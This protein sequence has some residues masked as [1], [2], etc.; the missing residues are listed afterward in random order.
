MS[1]VS[2]PSR[3]RNS[4]PRFVLV[5]ART[6]AD[7]TDLDDL[8]VAHR[9]QDGLVI[10]ASATRPWTTGQYDEDSYEAT[11]KPLLELGRGMHD[12]KRTFGPKE[13]VDPVRF[14]IG[15]AAGFGGLP[16]EEAFYAI[17]THPQPVGRF[18]LTVKEPPL[19]GFW[20]VSIYNEDG[21]FQENQYDSYSVN[22]VTAV[23]GSDGSVTVTFGPE[24]DGSD[25]FLHVMDGWNYAARMY[26]PRP[27]ILNG[28]WTFPEPEPM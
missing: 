13:Q 18:R 1:T 9:L 14:L 11:K 10:T 2:I 26:R 5:V 23:P 8:A 7:P 20:S 28:T 6:L 22:S 25:N 15:S 21:Y 17:K 24:P 4:I 19:D 27:A 16:E 12:S 3:W